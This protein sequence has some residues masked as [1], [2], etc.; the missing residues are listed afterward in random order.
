[1]NNYR[2]LKL[3]SVNKYELRDKIIYPDNRQPLDLFQDFNI[4]DRHCQRDIHND[5]FLKYVGQSRPMRF[6]LFI[7][8]NYDDL[9]EAYELWE[10]VNLKQG[11]GYRINNLLL[12]NHHQYEIT[13]DTSIKT[14]DQV[15]LFLKQ[16][17]NQLQSVIIDRYYDLKT[18]QNIYRRAVCQHDHPMYN[19]QMTIIYLSQ[20]LQKQKPI[21]D[22]IILD[23]TTFIQTMAYYIYLLYSLSILLNESIDDIIDDLIMTRF[24]LNTVTNTILAI[25]LEK[26]D[27]GKV[28]HLIKKYL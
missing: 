25:Y 28:I 15:D 11:R 18:V 26:Y 1:M 21:V 12:L 9:G 6:V 8:A 2:P 4:H 13:Y 20:L 7:H 27:I 3:D 22:G 10:F 17:N 16:L 23:D 24:D 5:E 19:L 14:Y